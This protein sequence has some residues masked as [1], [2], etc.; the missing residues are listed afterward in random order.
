M[1]RESPRRNQTA[2]SIIRIF[3]TAL[4]FGGDLISSTGGGSGNFFF[5]TSPSCPTVRLLRF[6][7]WNM[8]VLELEPSNA[9][10]ASLIDRWVLFGRIFR[11]RFYM[12][13]GNGEKYGE[14]F[15]VI[16]FHLVAITRWPPGKNILR[17]EYSEILWGMF[18]RSRISVRR[19][20]ICF[21]ISE[22]RLPFI[23]YDEPI[24]V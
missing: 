10:F 2:V 5:L 17:G 4:I 22:L 1:L 3:R 21:E 12:V 7:S 16:C 13:C 8:F 19:N 24:A 9:M 11:G 14:Y 20:R 23:R 15:C 6:H 18:V